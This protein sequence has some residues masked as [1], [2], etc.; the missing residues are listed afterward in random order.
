[1]AGV[2]G[3][4]DLTSRGVSVTV[5]GV[6]NSGLLAGGTTFNYQAAGPDIAARASEL[7]TACG[8]YGVPLPAAAL[9]FSVSHP[10]I[11]RALIGA[12]SSAEVSQDVSWLCHPIP[13]QLWHDLSRR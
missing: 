10:A 1:M 8:H 2:V 6:F 3:W 7:A 9:Q 4:A 13:D 11:A 12:R 5:G